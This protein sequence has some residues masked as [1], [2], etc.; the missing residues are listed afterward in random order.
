M[1]H[2]RSLLFIPIN[3]DYPTVEYEFYGFT[4][5][6]DITLSQECQDNEHSMA[7]QL[8][9]HNDGRTNLTLQ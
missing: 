1:S 7:E 4:S 8:D 5:L 2:M 6:Y 3:L 9:V